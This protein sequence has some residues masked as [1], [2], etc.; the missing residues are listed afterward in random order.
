M[1]EVTEVLAKGEEGVEP[2]LVQALA[3]AHLGQVVL[4]NRLINR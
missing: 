1:V 3:V 4:L 2:L